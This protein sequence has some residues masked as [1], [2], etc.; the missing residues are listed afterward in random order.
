M[1]LDHTQIHALDL[2]SAYG[3]LFEGELLVKRR[4]NPGCG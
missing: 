3:R 1:L 4:V 2:W